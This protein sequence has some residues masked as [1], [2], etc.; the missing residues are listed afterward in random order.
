VPWLTEEQK[1]TLSR[2]LSP[3][4]RRNRRNNVDV[5][6]V[7]FYSSEMKGAKQLADQLAIEAAGRGTQDTTGDRYR[8]TL[9]NLGLLDQQGATPSGQAVL[10]WAAAN[11]AAL[12]DPQQAAEGVDRIAFEGLAQLLTTHPDSVPAKFFSGLLVNLS[13]FVE[14]IPEPERAALADDLEL[15]YVLQFI[16]SSGDEIARLWWLP[17]ADRAA[18][19]ESWRAAART[20]PGTLTPADAV[21][22]TIHEYLGR[23]PRRAGRRSRLPTPMASLWMP[24][25][26]Q[27]PSLRRAR[28]RT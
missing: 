20:F 27:E 6:H 13:D 19:I 7:S 21:E 4:P 23:A 14:A 3:S 9:G 17:P 12:A 10:A 8:N 16:H 2:V 18:F 24:R 1:A 11:A 22:K 28:P 26:G 15:L 25:F 5:R